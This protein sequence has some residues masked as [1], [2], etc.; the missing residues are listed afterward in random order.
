[1]TAKSPTTELKRDIKA[2]L[3]FVSA[4][5]LSSVEHFSILQA[6][7]FGFTTHSFDTQSRAK[8]RVTIRYLLQVV[9]KM[10]HINANVCP[11]L[12]NPYKIVR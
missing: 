5:S 6:I 2:A 11:C 12:L 3:I 1:M 10:I 7:L 4:V 8:R 9:R